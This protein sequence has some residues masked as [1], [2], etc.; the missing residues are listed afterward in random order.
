[1]KVASTN[2]TPSTHS[3]ITD[4]ILRRQLVYQ[5]AE[6][7]ASRHHHG[8]LCSRDHFGREKWRESGSVGGGWPARAQ[9]RGLCDGLESWSQISSRWWSTWP[10]CTALLALVVGLEWHCTESYSG[11]RPPK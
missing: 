5:T 4:S 7:E 2:A 9:Q 3:P 10:G 8:C 11:V 6:A 1:M